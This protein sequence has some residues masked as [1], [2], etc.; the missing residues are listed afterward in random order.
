MTAS[1]GELGQAKSFCLFPV[2]WQVFLWGWG[3]F[4]LK[5]RLDQEYADL[6]KETGV[7]IADI[8]AALRVFDKLFPMPGGWFKE[9]AD[10]SR[11]VLALMPAAMRGVGAFRR[12]VRSETQNYADLGYK[13]ATTGRL[14]Q[15]HNTVVRLLDVNDKDLVK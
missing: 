6:E 11:K 13:D 9:P 14:V 1:L 8:P 5:D 2:F 7:P 3:G 4:L 12:S 15:D 10:D